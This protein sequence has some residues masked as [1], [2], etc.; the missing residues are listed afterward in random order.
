VQV[1][2]RRGYLAATAAAAS[3]RTA[4]P[5][6][7]ASSAAEA[8]ESLAVGVVVGSLSRFSREASL[9]T[10]AASGWNARGAAAVWVVGEVAASER[11]LGGGEANVTL[12]RGGAPVSTARATIAPGGRTFRVAIASTDPLPAGEYQVRV[13]ATGAAGT[14]PP[15][16][17]L[18]TLQVAAAAGP[19]GAL[20]IR[21]GLSTGNKSVATAD[22]RFRRNERL[23][24]EVPMSVSAPLRARLLD[25]TGKPLTTIP[26]AVTPRTDADGS[27]WQTAEVA[28]APLAPGDYV[29]ELSL[30]A[31]ADQKRTLV[32]FRIIP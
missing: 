24:V 18:V 23:G 11:W 16:D 7:S 3:R 20:L 6:V 30:E 1:R 9:R 28:L 14:G 22:S 8:A 19:I 15:L 32:P 10:Q 17:D 26:V 2:A 25:R 27:S 13:R 31:A 29:V 12:I 5:T 21:R 4:A